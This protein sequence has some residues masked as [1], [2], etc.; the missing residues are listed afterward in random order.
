MPDKKQVCDTAFIQRY[1][2]ILP[3]ISMNIIKPT[4]LVDKEKCILNI[5]RMAGKANKHNLFFRPHFKTHQSAKIG[6]WFKAEGVKA[7]TVSSVT[8]ADY[9]ARHGW[10]V[11]TIAFPVN[12]LELVIINQL[13]TPHLR[14]QL[15]HSDISLHG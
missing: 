9:F 15:S 8:M 2:N 10:T 6:S 7:I 14:Q 12:I 13:T 4:L 11:I 1:S 5:Q 3:S